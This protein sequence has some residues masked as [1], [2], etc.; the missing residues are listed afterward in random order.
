[1]F[2]MAINMLMVT[3]LAPVVGIPLPWISHGG[4]AMMTNMICLG[5]IMAVDRWSR[6]SGSLSG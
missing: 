6:S 4:S 2:Y 5:T 3:G 1:F